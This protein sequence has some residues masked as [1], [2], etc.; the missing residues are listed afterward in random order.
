MP[1]KTEL[2]WVFSPHFIVRSTGFPYELIEALHM[3]FTAA[4]VRQAAREAVSARPLPAE[5][6]ARFIEEWSRSRARF[7]E[8]V[9][10]DD[11]QEA[12]FLSSPDMYENTLTSFVRSWRPDKQRHKERR[13]EHKLYLYLQRFCTKNETHSFFGPLD[14]GRFNVDGVSGIDVRQQDCRVTQCV[15]HLAHWAVATLSRVIAANP[16]VK[17][18]LPVRI[19]PVY[20]ISATGIV[21]RTDKTDSRIMLEGSALSMARQIDGCCTVA[22]AGARANLTDEDAEKAVAR[23]IELGIASRDLEVGNDKADAL[24]A[25]CRSLET[26]L[27][28]SA[29]VTAWLVVLKQ[30]EDLCARFAGSGLQQR[31]AVLSEMEA[32]FQRLTGV[33]P[34]RHPGMLYGDRLLVY[35]ECRGSLERMDVGSETTRSWLDRLS[36]PLKLAALVGER[37]WLACQ[38]RCLESFQALRRGR[39]LVHLAEFL[40]HTMNLSDAAEAVIE[41]PLQSLLADCGGERVVRICSKD[42]PHVTVRPFCRYGL[43]DL[44]LAAEDIQALRRGDALLVIGGIHS[45]CL[46][47][48]WMTIF[49]PCPEELTAAFHQWQERVGHRDGM[50]ALELRRR[51]KAFYQFPGTR[52]E[53]ADRALSAASA[54]PVRDVY[55]G[56]FDGYI[57]ACV[58]HKVLMGLYLSMV[59]MERDTRFVALSAPPLLWRPYRCDGHTPRVEVDGIVMQRER[60]ETDVAHLTGLSGLELMLEL[61]RLKERLGLPNEV[62][63]H[64]PRERKPLYV[65]FASHLSLEVFVSMAAKHGQVTFVEMLPG[66]AGLWR[67]NGEGHLCAELRVGV[68]G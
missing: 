30:F 20:S 29:T 62:F 5:A 27:G 13:A 52:I 64:I 24:S 22:E 33:K 35:E 10:R 25:L 15:A 28:Q 34:R 19:N 60:W 14:Y 68:Y 67:T 36:G 43:L 48:N 61:W 1:E 40:A 58:G 50:A 63:A 38:Q 59:D 45:Q 49:H 39:E 26:Q 2:S 7:K 44:L 23:L 42:I 56:I 46:I 65:D 12:V 16:D 3:P 17:R 32:L 57:R 9:E 47:P 6:E 8:I 51:N 54:V 53:I 41:H 37:V 4:W 11:F 55:V 31:R 18:H 21:E 66:P